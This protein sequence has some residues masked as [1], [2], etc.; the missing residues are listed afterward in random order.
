LVKEGRVF[1][2]AGLIDKHDE[3]Q[4]DSTRVKAH[5]AASMGRRLRGE[6]NRTPTRV[7][8]WAGRVAG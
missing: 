6:K 3:V 7:D 2:D 5:P 8:A 4:R 1:S